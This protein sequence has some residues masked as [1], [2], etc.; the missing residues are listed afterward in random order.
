MVELVAIIEASRLFWVVT[1]APA[2]PRAFDVVCEAEF[3]SLAM[4]RVW[5]ISLEVELRFRVP[6]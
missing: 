2:I 3:P 6:A 5:L 4:L 1:D